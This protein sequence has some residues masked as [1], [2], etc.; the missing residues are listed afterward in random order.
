MIIKTDEVINTYIANELKHVSLPFDC[1]IWDNLNTATEIQVLQDAQIEGKRT[2]IHRLLQL[3]RVV[4]STD[5][6]DKVYGLLGLMDESLAALVKPDYEDTVLNVYR[7]FM[8]AIVEA[9]G[10]LEVVR[11]AG[12]TANF[13]FPSWVPDWTVPPEV[14]VMT[15]SDDS[16]STSGS[17]IASIQPLANGLLLSCK[18]LI[19]DRFDGMGCMWAKGWSPNSVVPT[20]STA[21]PYGT[22]ERARDAI[23]KSMVVCHSLPSEPLNA[24]YGSLLATPVLANMDLSDHS[25]L[26]ELTD[27][28]VFRWCVQS[29]EGNA[30]FQVAGRRMEE[31]FWKRAEPED[32]DHVHLRDALMQRDRVNLHRRLITTERGYV[33]MALETVEKNDVV[34]VL[35]GCSTPIVLRKVEVG[36]GH[37]RWQVVGECYIHGIM[38]GEAME[39]GIEAQDIILC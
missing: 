2:N 33:G 29:L 12:P 34:A 15:I 39:W 23:W 31:Y 38:D 3:S 14:T 19:V 13:S 20:K 30:E 4:L 17:S 5:P 32:I 6:R 11:H 25:P 28:N 9:T 22:F 16:F 27:S 1:V 37:V 36:S 35:L 8:L 26:K 18:G 21:D 24:D 10:S 7:S